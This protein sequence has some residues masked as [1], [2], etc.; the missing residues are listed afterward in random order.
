MQRG[1]LIS[2]NCVSLLAYVVQT[3][4]C[5]AGVGNPFLCD[6]RTKSINDILKCYGSCACCTNQLVCSFPVHLWC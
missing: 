2:Q 5:S 4:H 1:R 6:V 3:L